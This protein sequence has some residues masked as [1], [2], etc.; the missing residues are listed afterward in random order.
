MPPAIVVPAVDLSMYA[1]FAGY[2][3]SPHVCLSLQMLFISIIQMRPRNCN[4]MS[5]L[6]SFSSLHCRIVAQLMMAALHVYNFLHLD[7]LT[8]SREV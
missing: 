2:T 7:V 3:E 1:V 4:E 6:S 5:P 8:M